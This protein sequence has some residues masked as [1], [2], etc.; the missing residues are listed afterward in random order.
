MRKLTLLI[1]GVALGFVAAHFINQNPE[2][3]RFFERLNRGA[4]QIS[5]AVVS[6]YREAEGAVSESFPNAAEQRNDADSR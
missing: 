5:D 2:G 1:F 4:Q 3:R 6:G